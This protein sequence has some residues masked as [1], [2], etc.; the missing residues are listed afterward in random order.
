MR[1]QALNGFW[2]LTASVPTGKWPARSERDRNAFP[3]LLMSEFDT[4][5]GMPSPFLSPGNR[6][7][8]NRYCVKMRPS[9]ILRLFSRGNSPNSSLKYLQIDCSVSKPG[10]S[11]CGVPIARPK[12]RPRFLPIIDASIALR[13]VGNSRAANPMFP[14]RKPV[15][16]WSCWNAGRGV[17]CSTRSVLSLE[18][19]IQ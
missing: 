8:G 2:R 18:R 14:R 16:R 17:R 10:I 5:W 1:E 15:M 13:A 9:H 3:T 11:G 7:P 19:P 12:L 6:S 4:K